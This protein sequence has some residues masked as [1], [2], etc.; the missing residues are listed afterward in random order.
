MNQQCN[1]CGGFKNIQHCTKGC[2]SLICDNCRVNHENVCETNQKKI[3]LGL[4]P[5]VRGSGGNH[6]VGLNPP[7]PTPA[8][9]PRVIAK[10]PVLGAPYGP[11]NELPTTEQVAAIQAAI[12]EGEKSGTPLL[13]GP[14]I[15][16]EEQ[17]NASS[18]EPVLQPEQNAS[19]S[20][21]VEGSTISPVSDSST[22]GAD[23][24]QAQAGWRP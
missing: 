18:G 19:Q 16:T 2:H 13:Q 1:S 14:A 20:S 23:S 15:V 3:D 12:T 7:E 4:G 17:A 8:P 10:P 5:T 11:Q 24:E 9:P 22:D 21:V 6:S